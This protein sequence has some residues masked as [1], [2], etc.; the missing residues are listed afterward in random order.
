MSGRRRAVLIA[1]PTASGKSALALERAERDGG[2]I[3]NADALQVYDTLRLLTARPG[4]QETTRRPHLLYGT[5]PPATRF[6]TGH[7]FAAVEGIIKQHSAANLLVFVGGTG[8]YFDA[9]L[10]GLAPVP[11]VPEAVL[12]AVE[13]QVQQLDAAQRL[14]LLQQED[15]E[16]A[17]KLRIADPQ[18][19]MRAL[20]VKRA[21]GKPLSAFQ[22]E[23]QAGL[24]GEFEI[25]RMVLDPERDLLRRRIAR[26]FETMFD[27]GAVEEVLALRAQQLDPSLPVM[28]AI[29]VREIGEYLE[30]RIARDEA[31][32]LATTAT[33]QYAKRQRTWLRNRF[34]DWPRH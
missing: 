33:H 25:E 16:T 31:V 27:A 23:P 17:A 6:S 1:G 10:H 19:L 15:P 32:R 3:I 21:T 22:A 29:G 12:A 7:W 20:A 26:R 28:K 9:L 2:I 13:A 34:A 14:S 30:G 18:R 8:L 11:K 5:V 4:P 24:L